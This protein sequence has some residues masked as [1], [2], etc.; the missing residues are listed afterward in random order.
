MHNHTVEQL[1]RLTNLRTY[2]HLSCHRMSLLDSSLNIVLQV[3]GR[4]GKL[5]GLRQLLLSLHLTS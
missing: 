1:H 5:P 2:Y 4:G 3:V